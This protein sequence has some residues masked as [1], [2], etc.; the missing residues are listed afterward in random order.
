MEEQTEEEKQI[1]EGRMDRKTE[2]K[3]ERNDGQKSEKALRTGR[4]GR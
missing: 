3:R 4:Y 1:R 2:R